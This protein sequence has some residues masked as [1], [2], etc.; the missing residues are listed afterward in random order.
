MITIILNLIFWLVIIPYV[1]GMALTGFISS[2]EKPKATSAK[3]NN[4]SKPK[5]IPYTKEQ[6]IVKA[7]F[8][9]LMK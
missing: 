5:T 6:L 1:V 7:R 3:P 2:T 8:N 4:Y 9:A